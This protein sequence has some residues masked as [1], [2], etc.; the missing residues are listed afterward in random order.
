MLLMLGTKVH[1]QA[2]LHPVDSPILKPGKLLF[3]TNNIYLQD[4]TFGMM[5][6][7]DSSVNSALKPIDA[8]TTKELPFFCAMECRVRKHTKLWIKV[9]TGNDDSY[10]K[11]IKPSN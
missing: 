11:M 5:R 1:A 2:C 9:R 10:M 7:D 6:V 8:S 4:P 3:F